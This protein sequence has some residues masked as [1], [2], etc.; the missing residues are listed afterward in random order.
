M[1]A[2]IF[3]SEG[4]THQGVAL[5]NLEGPFA[6]RGHSESVLHQYDGPEAEAVRAFAA[7]LGGIRG[8]HLADTSPTTL[9]RGMSGI[10][11][12]RE[13]YPNGANLASV[14][15]LLSKR[16]KA[17]FRLVCSTLQLVAPFIAELVVEPA[18]QSPQYVTIQWRQRGTDGLFDAGHLSDGTLRFLAL[19]T[20]LLQPDPPPVILLDE[21]ELGLH[22]HALVTLVEL[23]RQAAQ[24]TQVVIATQSRQVVDLVEVEH[25]IVAERVEGET[26]LTRPDAAALAKWLEDYSLGELWDMNVLSALG[27]DAR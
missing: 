12:N 26:T 20:V 21:P 9:M 22:P 8:W 7:G 5:H 25:V 15:Y 1:D 24:R 10:N 27:P 17:E 19:A 14:L 23:L 2:L 6:S 18:L 11:D 13:L 4:F 3:L 16:H